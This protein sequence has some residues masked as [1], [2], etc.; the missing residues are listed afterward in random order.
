MIK[1][2]LTAAFIIAT[3]AMGAQNSKLK[4]A[5]IKMEK[6]EDGKVTRVDTCVTAATDEEL[7]AKLDALGIGIG[8]LPELPPLPSTPPVP[9]VP[10]VPGIEPKE[11]TMTK[12]IVIDDGEE[13]SNGRKQAGG[14]KQVKVVSAE[15]SGEEANVVVMDGKGNVLTDDH[16]GN[17][18]IKKLKPGEKLD[19]E[20]E[21]MIKEHGVDTKDGETHK[22]VIRNEDNKNGKK[23]SEVKVFVFSKVEVKKLSSEDKK[24]LPADATKLIENSSPFNGLS[25]APNPTE[26]ASN[27]TYKSS[28]KEPL[29][30]SVY[31][32]NGK[33]VYNETD[34]NTGD[35][36]NKTLSLKE[37]GKGIYF[38]HL[39]QGK[40]S[41]VRKVIVK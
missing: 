11:V 4:K 15:G 12:V 8:E 22:I 25:V 30:I 29:Q 37:L 2:T 38:V 7:Q 14:R 27:I 23:S 16:K 5:C 28:G 9:P 24:Q 21:K 40:Q 41:E 35:Q 13:S 17:V 18:V 10:P 32:M 6:D 34:K 36:V 39:T 20:I 19:P 3:I 31:D 26:D 1:R 33:T